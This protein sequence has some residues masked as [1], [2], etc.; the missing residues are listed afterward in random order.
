MTGQKYYRSSRKHRKPSLSR[1]ARAE[2]QFPVSR[3]DRFLRDRNYAQR[4]RPSSPVFFTGILEYLMAN[5]LELAGEE[6]HNHH[7]I[8]IT[9]EH[10]EK[11]VGSNTQ[12]SR[13]LDNGAMSE[14][15]ETTHPQ[16]N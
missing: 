2:L 15:D 16:K 10:V 1:S 8:R 7:R 12:L 4:L 9:P 5:V 14:A 6:A 3:V 11:A 13:L